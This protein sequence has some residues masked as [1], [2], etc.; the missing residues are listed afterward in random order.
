MFDVAAVSK[1]D[2]LRGRNKG[3]NVQLFFVF[4]RVGWKRSGVPPSLGMAIREAWRKTPVSLLVW[5][6]SA[7]HR[8]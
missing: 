7:L 1:D 8:R 2:G 5:Q 6:S 3:T 4:L